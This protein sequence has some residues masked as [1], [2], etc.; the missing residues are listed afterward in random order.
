EGA[1]QQYLKDNERPWLHRRKYSPWPSAR[2]RAKTVWRM[3]WRQIYVRG[4]TDQ[5]PESIFVVGMNVPDDTDAAGL[6]QL[7]TFDAQRHVRERMSYAGYA[8]VSR[9]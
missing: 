3:L 5:A 6:A 8:R 2:R 1:A 4:S 9:V 7:N